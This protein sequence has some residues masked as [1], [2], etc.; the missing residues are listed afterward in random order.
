MCAASEDIVYRPFCDSD[1]GA[2]TDLCS[3]VWC[4]GVEGVYD[5]SVFG[6]VM[7][8]GA[9]RRSQVTLV[10]QR[11]GV[12]VGAIF[13]GFCPN[14]SVQVN[15]SWEERFQELMVIARKR[16][17]NGGILVEERLFSKLRMFT[18][19]DVFISRGYTNSQSE[20]NLLVVHPKAQGQGI[21]DRLLEEML[22]SFSSK[23]AQGS[24]IVIDEDSDRE[25][26][27]RR[28]FNCVQERQ[29]AGGDSGRRTIYLY[30]RR[31]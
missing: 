19:A 16:A 26:L 30:G 9:L 6:R 3:R 24:F 27:E 21:G 29:G 22:V 7:T 17:K 25:F 15:E 31:L 28:G 1:F 23:G 12:V 18:M 10:A 14:E 11:A 2:V 4:V 8:A 20:I 5:R 13:G